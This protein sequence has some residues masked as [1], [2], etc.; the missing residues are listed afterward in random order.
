MRFAAAEEGALAWFG[1]GG[2]ARFRSSGPSPLP[3][4]P[5]A[6]GLSPIL[7]KASWT[8][9]YITQFSGEEVGSGPP[10]LPT[11]LVTFLRA[12]VGKQALQE[13][14]LRGPWDQ[15]LLFQQPQQA[16]RLIRAGQRADL[17]RQK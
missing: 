11:F 8:H 9:I 16:P 7:G 15:R 2:E 1:S 6:H 4:H 10:G 3:P 14:V 12:I 17:W 13:G 5:K